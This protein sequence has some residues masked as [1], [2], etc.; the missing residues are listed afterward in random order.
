MATP[1]QSEI[2]SGPGTATP[3]P[4]PRR[5]AAGTV[6]LLVGINAL[7]GGS[8]LAAKLALGTS[9]HAHL[10]PMTLAFMRFALAALLMYAVALWRRVDMRVARKDW[11]RFWAMGVLGLTAAY[12][13]SYLGIQRTAASEAALLIAT[14]P[15]YL[16]L[17]SV[18]FLHETLAAAKVGGIVAGLV[19]VVLIVTEGKWQG[20]V[21]GALLG[22]ILIASGLIF[23]ALS[24]IVGK[25]LVTRYPI[26]AVMTYQMTCGAV[27]L[28]PLAAWEMFHAL[29]PL[30][31]LSQPPAV[32]WS[33]LYLVIPCTVFAYTV[34]FSLLET[35][36]ASE[37]SVFLFL[38]PVVGMVLGVWLLHEGVTLPKFLG[39]LLVLLA[40][41]LINRRPNPPDTPPVPPSA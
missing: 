26:P 7:W 25:K 2:V 9:L 18:V 33:L 1:G 30:A 12:L 34:W 31:V 3:F 36:D 32:W 28:A 40:V 11:A 13:L 10:P 17:L 5:M 27:A 37:L 4:R 29:P 8:S 23:E 21:S 14:E 24:S 35:H 19:G 22:D 6:L 41:S 38:Q 15:V 39:A 16:A 20:R